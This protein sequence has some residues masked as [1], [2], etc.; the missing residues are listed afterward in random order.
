MLQPVLDEA[1]LAARTCTH[2]ALNNDKANAKG[3]VR[4]ECA[5]AIH[6]MRNKSWEKVMDACLQRKSWESVSKIWWE[7]L[8]SMCVFA[9]RSAWFLI[10]GAALGRLRNDSIAMGAAHNE[11]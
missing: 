9:W 3:K 11:V 6:F 2:A 1:G 4:M 10:N 8:A 5:A 7:N